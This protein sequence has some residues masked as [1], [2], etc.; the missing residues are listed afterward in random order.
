MTAGLCARTAASF[1]V[2]LTLGATGFLCFAKVGFIGTTLRLGAFLIAFFTARLLR[3][4]FFLTAPFFATARLEATRAFD[5]AF[6]FCVFLAT[7]F[8]ATAL[9]AF[10]RALLGAGLRPLTVDF[11]EERRATVREVE[12]LRVFVAAL[13]SKVMTERPIW[14]KRS[15]SCGGRVT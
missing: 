14:T 15:G 2:F 6:T 1:W 11:A 12:R 9:L 7:T 5:A 13:I 10:G 4:T 8:F 3:M